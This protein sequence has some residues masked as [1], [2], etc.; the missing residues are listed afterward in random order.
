MNPILI[1]NYTA[2]ATVQA[3]R[4]VK[5][6]AA[7]FEVLHATAADSDGLI[8]VTNELG[9]PAQGRVDVIRG[10][11]AE[12]ELGGVVEAGDPITSDTGGLGVVPAPAAG[13]NVRIIGFAEIAGVTGDRIPVL[14]APGQ[15]QG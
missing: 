13:A 9:A 12:V 11:L 1:K 10:G 14:V 15:I 3:Y 5:F 4:I 8:G 7:D 6:G 2:E